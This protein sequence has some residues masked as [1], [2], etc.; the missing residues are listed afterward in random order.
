MKKKGV[1]IVQCNL[2]IQSWLFF[3][4]YWS[5]WLYIYVSF[6]IH[7]FSLCYCFGFFG[8]FDF[9]FHFIQCEYRMSFLSIAHRYSALNATNNFTWAQKKK[10]W[11]NWTQLQQQ[12][13][14]KRKEYWNCSEKENIERAA[15]DHLAN[16]SYVQ[17]DEK[18][19][20]Q[21]E[22]TDFFFHFAFYF[23]VVWL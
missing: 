13:C 3:H 22:K 17:V 1:R 19:Q 15:Y 6:A 9:F 21:H 16:R 14:V 5:T 2:H 10:H 11:M 8:W 12:K 7:F 20:Q 23:V 4:L 18:R